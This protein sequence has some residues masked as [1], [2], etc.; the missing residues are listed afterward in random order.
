MSLASKTSTSYAISG[1]LKT[2]TSGD[3]ELT[4]AGKVKEVEDFLALLSKKATIKLEKEAEKD[5]MV[6][7]GFELIIQNNVEHRTVE[8]SDS[9]TSREKQ[10]QLE[11]DKLKRNY[12]SIQRSK[13]WRY[14]LPI[15]KIM[16]VVKRN[17]K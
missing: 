6:S 4:I 13:L 10:L 7:V 2:L 15:R 3:T 16:N 9:A 11:L 5:L 17:S 8:A 14:S 1:Y 12:E